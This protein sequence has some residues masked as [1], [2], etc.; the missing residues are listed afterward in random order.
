[1]KT[2]PTK[3]SRR[4]LLRKSAT[5]ALGFSVMPSYLALGKPDGEGNVPPSQRINL[6]CVGVGGRAASVIPGLCTNGFAQPVALCDV[7]LNARNIEKNLERYPGAKQF[8]DFRIMLDKMGKDI[9]AVSVVTPD[10]T[11]YVAAIAAMQLG[12]HVYVEKP[13]THT[14]READLLMQAEKKYKVVTQMGNQG[15]TSSGSEQFKRLVK[16][17]IIKDIV[18]I[19]AWKS[20]GLW[21]M[22]RNKRIDQYPT[23]EAKPATLNWD[24]W[25]GP[26]EMKPFSPKY[27]P[28][29]WRGFHLYGAGMLGDWGAHIIDFAHDFLKLGLPTTI[30][31]I[32]MADHNQIIFP[33]ISKLA[34]RFPE[35]G[36]GLPA[37]EM[38]WE[39]SNEK[40]APE[41]SRKFWDGEKSPDLRG[42]GTLLHRKDGAFVVQRGS[43]ASVS[44]IY[45]RD[46]MM[47]Y[48]DDLKVPG[49]QFNHQ[50][51]F[52]QACLG[53]GTT[54]SPFSVAAPLT[55]V[56]LLGVIC[57]YLNESLE[58]DP[59]TET[60]KGNAAANDLLAG[61]TPRSGWEGF[62]EA[63]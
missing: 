9:D 60:F 48:K 29:S 43:H 50:T 1:M 18:K 61:P 56:L 39:D 15:H 5:T 45:P 31:A 33:L 17:G 25:C 26:K 16:K 7:D 36:D 42:A 53:N 59:E 24:L 19:E 38:I 2:P 41:V 63:I 34:M 21:F 49:P 8:A 57:Q 28:F 13:L 52:I 55:K 14:Y 37:C 12:K 40:C 20:G 46:E 27:H 3:S 22:D 11:H 51:S 32:E 6:G 54:N 44:R 30:E 62:Y 10:H 47:K 35:R 23:G 4:S 58:F